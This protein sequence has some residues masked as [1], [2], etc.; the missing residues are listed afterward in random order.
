MKKNNFI[1]KIFIKDLIQEIKDNCIMHERFN[2][3]IKDT[4]IIRD[5]N[6]KI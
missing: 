1:I 5:T 2:L 4:L 6:K 3:D